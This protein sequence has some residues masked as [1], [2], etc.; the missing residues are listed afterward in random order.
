MRMLAL[1]LVF[2]A[3]YI[4]VRTCYPSCTLHNLVAYCMERHLYAVPALPPNITHIYLELNH[5]SEINSTSLRDFQ[6]LRQLDLGNQ[7]VQ[8]IIRNNAFLRQT[9]LTRLVLSNNNHLQLEPRAFAGLAKLQ[10]LDLGYCNLDNSILAENYLQ[11]L[12]ALETL[13]LFGNKIVRLQ[14]GLFFSNLTKFTQL[15]LKLNQIDRLCEQDLA[16]FRGKNFTLL[17]LESNHLDR[18]FRGKLDWKKCGNPFRGM[19]FN[20]LDLSR[21]GF[22]LS[23]SR[24]FF[25]AIEGTQIHHLIYSGHMGKG[26]SHD[27]LRDPDKSTFEGLVNSAVETLDL[28]KSRIFAL[29]MAVFSPLK[30]AKIID[31]SQN[32]INQ[33]K[34]NA[35]DGLQVHLR[36]LNLSYN[37]LGEIRSNTFTNL[38]DLR[39]LDLS[40]NHIGVLGYKAFSGL[41]DLQ[42]LNL[43]GNSL[44]DLG[45]PVSLPKLHFL[46]LGNNNLKS[47][48]SIVNLGMNSTYVNVEENRLTNLEDVYVILTNFKHLQSLFYGGNPIEWCSLDITVPLNNSLQILDL[49]D[50]S[51]HTIWTQGK[52]L[53]LFDHLENLLG[54]NL[55]LN[56]LAALPEG[57]FRGL[58]SI[59]ELNLSSNAL[60]YLQ[61]D[62][63]PVSLKR[64]DLSKNFL[65]FPDPTTFQ[66]LLF[67][68]LAEIRF[69]C[70]C[71]LESFLTWLNV[72]NIT[73]LSPV[74]DYRCEFPAFLHNL[75]LLEY[76]TIVEPCEEDDER[77]VQ[78]LKFA[79]FIFSA[80]LV[81][82][83][84]L[85]GLIYAR[86]R[87]HI[88]IIYKKVIGRVLEG[89]KPP[90]PEEEVQYDVFL[91]FSN[92]DYEWV[93]AALLKKFDKEFSENNILRCCF[94]ARDF[95]PGVDHLSNNR[96]AIWGSRKTVCIVSKEFLKDGWC[97]EVFTLAQGRMLEE[98]TNVL[99][100]LVVGEVAHY[101]LM[102][103]NAVR[104][105]VE[106][107]DYLIWPNDPQ[108]LEWFYERLISQILK[109]SKVKN[110]AEDKPEPD[111]QP[112]NEDGIQ[113][114]NIGAIAM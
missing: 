39:V 112:Q 98:L 56:S 45:F 7:R 6:H 94:E 40:Y 31:I 64:L 14:P 113:L 108:D 27:N 87:G 59:I 38:T 17:N 93:E 54:L 13:D 16:G 49:H 100:M 110:P 35:F 53:D 83:V 88:F 82:S 84:I 5:I 51:L 33:I 97:L 95:I 91:C 1:Q 106:R 79:L 32:E 22:S 66:S 61:Q 23:G 25:K 15:N 2:I 50:I 30:N 81:I 28:S 20:I 70:D 78:D 4:Q 103:C 48:S 44:R 42:A 10:Y 76:F 3:V 69:H 77:A 12:E 74:E 85:S 55:S 101:Q 105:F 58:S 89:P 86:L 37:L 72:T 96:D 114:E 99:I 109:N 52:C 26:F 41:P 73:F 18:M 80:F 36:M 46:L 90:P 67:L 75:P 19:A 92:N 102:K 57:I 71:N 9:N 21:N 63:F 24:Q 11:Q 29:Q 68:S 107:R 43:T 60:T 111:I 8:L 104:A 65:A 47:L 34:R 62:V